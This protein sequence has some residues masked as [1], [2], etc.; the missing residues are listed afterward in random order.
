PAAIAVTETQPLEAPA[1]DATGAIVVPT[2]P[3]APERLAAPE[4]PAAPDAPA[5]EPA[6]SMPEN[7]AD[8]APVIDQNALETPEQPRTVTPQHEESAPPPS[9]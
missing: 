5:S 8:A 6:A 2:A 9:L 3:A 1:A 7:V 4:A